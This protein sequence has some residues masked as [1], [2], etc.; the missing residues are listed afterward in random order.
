MTDL[1]N[2]LQ[3]WTCVAYN[4]G[5]TIIL[6]NWSATFNVYDVQTGREFDVFT[7]FEAGTGD[8]I[9]IADERAEENLK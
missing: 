5:D 3:A 2:S 4:D 9:D 6:W 1:I 8:Y 7:Q